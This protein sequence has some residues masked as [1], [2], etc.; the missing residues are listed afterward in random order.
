MKKK[1]VAGIAVAAAVVVAGGAY[2]GVAQGGSSQPTVSTKEVSASASTSPSASTLTVLTSPKGNFADSF[3]PFDPSTNDGTFGNIYE[4][5]F[6]FDSVTGKTFNLLGKSYAF[7]NGNKT[8]TV[9][10][11]PNAKWSDGVKF[12][13]Q[14]VVFT[15]NELKKYPAADTNNVWSQ[16]ESVKAV[17]NSKVVF[18]FKAVDIPF[19][20]QYVLGS[21]YIVPEH[22]WKSL[23][24]PTKVKLPWQK[25][26]GTGPF[27]LVSFSPQMY[28]FEA[29]KL[30][31]GG[32][33]KV[34][35]V[36]YPAYT[37][38]QTADLALASGEI[39]WS[40][41][42]IPDIQKT[43]VSADPKHNHYYFAAG[44][45]VEMYPN[46]N[47]P[48]LSQLPVREAINLAINR[49]VIQSKGETG[50]SQLPVPTSLIPS[51]MSWLNPNLQGTGKSFTVNDA[52]AVQI[53]EKAGFR[54]DSHGIFAKDG[55][56]LSFQLLTV[57][58]WSDWDEDA[59]LIKQELQQI[60]ININVVQQQFS[61][62]Y[63]LINPGAGLKPHYDLALSWTNEGPTPYTIYYDM[64]DSKGNFNIEQY[65]N[66]A[67]DAALTQF[68][69]TTNVS[70]QK[71]ALYKVESIVTQQLP[72]IPIF[73]GE[74]W[75]EYND[76]K[77]TGW[78]TKNNLWINPAPY[79]FQSA[80]II[81]DHLKPVK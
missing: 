27:K 81:M 67:V 50:Y 19:A 5:L 22:E 66:P 64:L 41:I 51:Q 1:H 18:T 16:L 80:A 60:G 33:P 78:P 30:Y 72:V 8:L 69:A 74:L 3:N 59:L 57:T 11:Q 14:D 20:E 43:Y 9:N 7:S 77:F 73:D 29:N 36:K 61:A 49:N 2:A 47:N 10:L 62:Y 45:V 6:Y 40:G 56:E 21:T 31:Y 15:F 25:A 65:R 76:A 26:I 24:D 48:L 54:R 53:L 42:D 68:A 13:A 23:G 71:Q 32:V 12:T 58:G 34:Q 52:K 17:G 44:S 70:Q 4:T 38:N 75:Y 35:Y 63:N 28:T 37:S 46:F 79:T 39:D 55:K